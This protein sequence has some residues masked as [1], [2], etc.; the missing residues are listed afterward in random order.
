[1]KFTL[2]NGLLISVSWAALIS[3]SP[4][5]DRKAAFPETLLI[6]RGILPTIS[7]DQDARDKIAKRVA[8]EFAHRGYHREAAELLGA[9]NTFHGTLGLAE[10]ATEFAHQGE[11]SLAKAYCAKAEEASRQ[12]LPML[13]RP[14]PIAFVE[15][16]ASCHNWEK[17]K[18]WI[19]TMGDS[20]DRSEANSK[21]YAERLLAGL[22]NLA[23]DPPMWELEVISA[24]CVVIQKSKPSQ[25]RTEQL[26]KVLQNIA[27]MFPVNRT[28]AYLILYG[29]AR[30]MGED[31]IQKEAIEGAIRSA[32]SLARDIEETPVLQAKTAEVLF[33]ARD[34]RAYPMIKN[35]RE[36]CASLVGFY[37]P[38]AL[39]AVA[40]VLEKMGRFEDANEAWKEAWQKAVCHVH[41]R[42][43]QINAIE[44]LLSKTRAGKELTSQDRNY[45]DSVQSGINSSVTTVHEPSM[46]VIKEVSEHFE[47]QNKANLKQSFKTKSKAK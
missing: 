14:I 44:V 16:E 23:E 19:L 17:A 25:L 28:D 42:A 27:S 2:T 36:S 30:Q 3:C 7:G 40:E 31:K 43:R 13:P 39:C 9:Q 35:A 21:L 22:A 20:Y 37:Q 1:M 24:K 11:K 47:A 15:A 34:D 18:D 5:I 46:D 38:P 33:Q 12:F 32:L 26:A 8:I 45:L 10:L 41:P 6:A 29:S 4:L